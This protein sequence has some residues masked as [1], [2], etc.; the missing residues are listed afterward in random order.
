[1]VIISPRMYTVYLRARL[2]NNY[3]LSVD[4]SGTWTFSRRIF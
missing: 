3:I 2:I 1:M 4:E